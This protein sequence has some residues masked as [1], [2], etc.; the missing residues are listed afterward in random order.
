MSPNRFDDFGW[1]GDAGGIERHGM[2]PEMPWAL[3]SCEARTPAGA[4]TDA[5]IAQRRTHPPW[6]T[7]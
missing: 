5:R 1:G 6:R 7:C 3:R 4:V 2:P